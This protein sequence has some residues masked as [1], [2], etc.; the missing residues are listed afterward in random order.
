[1]APEAEPLVSTDEILILQ[2][3]MNIAFGKAAADLAE[4]MEMSVVLSVPDVQILRATQLPGYVRDAIGSS[5]RISLVEQDFWGDFKGSAFLVLPAEASKALLAALGADPGQLAY[6]EG[7]L[8][9]TATLER[10][11]LMEVGNIVIGA[12]VGKLAE[13]LGTVVTYTPPSVAVDGQPADSLH[14]GLFDGESSAVVLR[15][16]FR[17]A[18]QDLDGFV[19]LVSSSE[20]IQW[21]RGALARF[22][23]RYA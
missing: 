16:L 14:A 11:T 3:L 9:P 7:L 21:L 12:C 10:E 13:L 23:A 6:D 4:V 20:S 2:E 1:M 17:F 18:Q 19:F 5:P 22:M 8:E 15:T